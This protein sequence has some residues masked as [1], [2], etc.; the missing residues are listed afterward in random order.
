MP[1]DEAT[2]MPLS[3]FPNGVGGKGLCADYSFLV[4]KCLPHPAALLWFNMALS[5]PSIKILDDLPEGAQLIGA[6]T[7]TGPGIGL[8]RGGERRQTSTI[9]RTHDFF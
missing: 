2:A 5:E 6:E 3:T 9:N 8:W 7:R 4:A 1:E